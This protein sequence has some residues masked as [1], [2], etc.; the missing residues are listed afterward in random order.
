MCGSSPPG[1]PGVLVA[2]A[3]TLLSRLPPGPQGALSRRAAN[4]R[5]APCRSPQLSCRNP[6]LLPHY[7][8]CVGTAARRKREKRRFCHPQGGKRGAPRGAAPQRLAAASGTAEGPACPERRRCHSETPPPPSVRVWGE[9]ARSGRAR[10]NRGSEATASARSSSIAC[11]PPSSRVKRDQ[12]G[13]K[14]QPGICDAGNHGISPKPL[15]FH[16]ESYPLVGM[17]T[18]PQHHAPRGT[19]VRPR[20][21]GTLCAGGSVFI[22]LPWDLVARVSSRPH[23]GWDW[24]RG[25]TWPLGCWRK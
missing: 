25:W 21:G 9:Q 7:S 22:L 19:A 6:R 14:D 11:E 4:A 16:P 12:P 10:G 2:G 3:A 15:V 17:V 23:Q 8:K 1:P 5:G 13:C 18:S 20:E 24:P